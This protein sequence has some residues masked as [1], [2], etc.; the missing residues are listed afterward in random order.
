[1]LVFSDISLFFSSYLLLISINPFILLKV[2]CLDLRTKSPS[3]YSTLSPRFFNFL[4]TSLDRVL[5][6]DPDNPVNQKTAG[7]ASRR[8]NLTL[9]H[10]LSENIFLQTLL[11]PRVKRPSKLSFCCPNPKFLFWALP[12]RVVLCPMGLRR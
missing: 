5:F 1:M 6:P 8:P 4:K 10:P 9:L 2:S 11:H 7:F 3:K 12:S